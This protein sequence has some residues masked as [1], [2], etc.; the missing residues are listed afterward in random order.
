MDGYYDD[1]DLFYNE[2]QEEWDN[3][4]DEKQQIVCNLVDLLCTLK[5]IDA[6]RGLDRFYGINVASFVDRH[7]KHVDTKR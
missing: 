4:R 5:V 6:G 2:D 7:W 3:I 1:F